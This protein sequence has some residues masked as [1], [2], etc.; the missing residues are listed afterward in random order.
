MEM[1]N[2]ETETTILT[3]VVPTETDDQ[4]K[5]KD[6]NIVLTSLENAKEKRS[7]EGLKQKCRHLFI[8]RKENGLCRH[9]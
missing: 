8:L 5:K 2:K 1:S 9:K 4:V 3:F 7:Q 6:L